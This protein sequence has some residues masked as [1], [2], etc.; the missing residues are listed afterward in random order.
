MFTVNQQSNTANYS[1]N[2]TI[3]INLKFYLFKYR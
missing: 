3:A 2:M 1:Y